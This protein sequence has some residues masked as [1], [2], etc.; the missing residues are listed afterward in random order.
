MAS[1]SFVDAMRRLWAE[2]VATLGRTGDLKALMAKVHHDPEL[3]RRF[4]ENPTAVLFQ[5]DIE[6]PPGI[7]VQVVENSDTVY[8]LVLPPMMD[9]DAPAG[10]AK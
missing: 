4:I 2:H 1:V 10:G 6:L 7:K 8:H 3:R 9:T 5:A